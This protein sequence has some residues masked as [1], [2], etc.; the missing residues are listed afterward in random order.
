MGGDQPQS[1][2]GGRIDAT[3]GSVGVK[4]QRC[5]QKVLSPQ[6]HWRHPSLEHA[7]QS[8]IDLEARSVSLLEPRGSPE[9][10]GDHSPCSKP[11]EKL[12]PVV[13]DVEGDHLTDTE[14]ECDESP[15][16]DIHRRRQT[17]RCA[18]LDQDESV[19]DLCGDG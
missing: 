19:Q 18:G 17:I 3:D 11:Q 9:G 2:E 5:L 10:E 7:G 12:G 16:A 14:S 6:L 13:E 4:N 15:P 1:L 8:M